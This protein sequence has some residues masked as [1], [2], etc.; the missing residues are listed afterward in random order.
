M[1]RKACEWAEKEQVVEENGHVQVLR[2]VR[3]EKWSHV[4][5][6]QGDEDQHSIE[7]GFG[8]TD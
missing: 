4:Q 3:Q 1:E 5:V 8:A 6:L 7:E 2:P